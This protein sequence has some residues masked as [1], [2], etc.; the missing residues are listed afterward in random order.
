MTRLQSPA[1]D[2]LRARASRFM[3]IYLWAHVPL[4]I[5]LMLGTENG[6][7]MAP[8]AI[9]G[10]AALGTLDW[11]RTG[12]G[13]GAQITISTCLALIVAFLVAQLAG[14][15]WQIDM[16][17][18]FFAAFATVGVFC[19]WRALV[20]YAGVVAA[21]HLIL[22]VLI[23]QAVF[24]GEGDL[25][26]VLLH[27]VVLIVQAA[28]LIWLA[29]RLTGAFSE[30]TEAV[31]VARQAQSDGER[32][33]AEQRLTAAQAA[34]TSRRHAEVQERVVREISA[35]LERLSAGNLKMPINSPAG[36]PF[37]AE[38]DALRDSYNN[39]I[40]KLGDV[41][42]RIESVADG[43]RTGSGEID[44]AAQ[45]L[46]SRAE[47]QAATLEQSAAALQ[48]LV[49]SVR[50]SATRAAEARDAGQQNSA[51]AQAGA[52]VV[53]DAIGAMRL[54]EKSATQINQIIEVIESIAFQTNLLALNA[55]IEAARAGDAGRGFAV[56]ASEVRGLAQRA[57]DSAREI[58]GLIAESTAHVISGSA[59][60]SKTGDSLDHILRIAGDV[61]GLMEGISAASRDQAVS[62]EEIN[63]GVSQLDQVTQQNAAVAEQTTAAAGSLRQK[64]AELMTVISG[65]RNASGSDLRASGDAAS[66]G[67]TDHDPAPTVTGGHPRP[68][69]GGHGT[70][71][72][73]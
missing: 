50:S 39:V 65:F 27:A 64:A 53:Q 72:A 46:S 1:L 10:L 12:G 63:V 60:V 28:A 9:A 36:N 52:E 21:H 17:M 33:A 3:A 14:H 54:I 30:A 25:A 24:P 41:L 58:R 47:T 26:R 62:L 16:H 48:L 23:P 71:H 40:R 5:V 43:V 29:Q 66:Y 69:H 11:W 13:E 55:G 67:W 37:P 44:H 18:Y 4:S 35:G 8:L 34:E 61:Q 68:V 15:S 49:S 56:V 51:R 31:S 7:L 22:N 32:L 59:L 20:A 42:D 38:Y 73:G 70:M 57:S 2:H 45:H 19:N 6:S